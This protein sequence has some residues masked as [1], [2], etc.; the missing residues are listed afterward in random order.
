MKSK[1]LF[2]DL[3]GT[4]YDETLSDK[5]R[6]E[7]LLKKINSDITYEV[8]YR[9]MQRAAAEYA[10]SPFTA[11]RI[12]FGITENEPYSNKNE[13]LYPNVLDVIKKLSV[14]YNLGIIANQPADTLERLKKDG[15]FDFFRICLLS[16]RE[17]LFKPD[18]KFFER[19]LELA[20]CLPSEAVMI[21]DRLENDIF[22]AKNIGMKTVRIVQGLF[23]V[24]KPLNRNYISDYEITDISELLILGS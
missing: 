18:E 23:S 21:G 19:A 7:K 11:A 2:F 3:G 10:P 6:V 13:K 20:E 9:E 5:E 8:F 1:W 24:Q 16:E 22:P 14:S 12:S 4:I 17:N 15:L